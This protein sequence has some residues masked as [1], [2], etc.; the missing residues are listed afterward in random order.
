MTTQPPEQPRAFAQFI[1]E[2]EEGALHADLSDLLSKI[3]AELQDVARDRGGKPKAKLTIDFDITLDDGVFM[4][5]GDV[6]HKLPKEVR[7]RSIFWATPGNNLSRSNPKQHEL[8]GKPAAVAA[9]A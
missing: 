2:V 8:F 3:V 7:Q 9:T 5:I 1:Q 6:R 4:V